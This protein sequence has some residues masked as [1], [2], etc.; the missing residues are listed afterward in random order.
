[1]SCEG[2]D[3][4]SKGRKGPEGLKGAWITEGNGCL[5]DDMDDMEI[6]N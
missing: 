2:I 4:G 1:M 6:V 5:A 3:L